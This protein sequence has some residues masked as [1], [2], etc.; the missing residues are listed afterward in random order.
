[1]Q[2]TL[3]RRLTKVALT[4]AVAGYCAAP[5]VAADGNLKAGQWN[6]VSKH[7]GTI[8]G[9]VPWITRS[10]TETS[11]TDKSH[12]TVTSDYSGR[13]G[14]DAGDK[15]FHIGDTVTVNWAI[16][17]AEG[18]LDTDN[19]ATKATVKWMSFSD[20]NGSDPK[21]LGTGDSYKIQASDADR[22]IGIKITPT[23]TTG[24]PN[25]ATELVLKDLSTDAGGGSD[26]D[27]IPEGPVVDENVH[28]VIYAAGTTTNLLDTQTMLNTDTTYKVLLWKDKAGG[29]AGSYDAGEEVT[30]QYD[31][32]W[33]F[34]GS[35]GIAGTGVGG[36]VNESYNNRDLVI[37]LTNAEAK[38]AFEGAEGGVTVGSYG[39]QGFGLSIDY[40]RK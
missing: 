7:T 39:I 9:T 24:D 3:K 21:E 6:I 17:D 11:D 2:A 27:D 14:N 20:Q 35:S 31:Y 16:G 32:R 12:V 4:L 8:Q 18:D 38:A 10:T 29:T 13:T 15:Q 37:P 25:V 33:K 36:I 1:M 5:A 34:T 19:T 30:S 28:V 22:Y 23:T 40:K 26:G